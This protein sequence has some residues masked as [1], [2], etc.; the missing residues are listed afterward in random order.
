[1]GKK[2]R[3]FALA[4]QVAIEAILLIVLFN[5]VSKDRLSEQVFWIAFSFSF[6]VN[7]LIAVA[8]FLFTRKK[9]DE[10]LTIPVLY[11]VSYVISAIYLVLGMIFMYVPLKDPTWVWISEAILTIIFII[12]VMYFLF[13][14]SYINRNA[15]IQKEKVAY[16]REAK[17][18]CDDA[19]YLSKHEESQKALQKLSEDIRFSDPMSNDSVAELE[20]ELYNT[21]LDIQIKLEESGDADVLD[22]VKTADRALKRRNALVKIR[23]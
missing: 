12:L 14:A 10:W 6:V 15:K 4:V 18:I 7:L 1:M 3:I 9:A 21:L 23:K 20:K 16:I 17:A 19:A 8:M 13:G 22:L 5:T 11:F 2:F